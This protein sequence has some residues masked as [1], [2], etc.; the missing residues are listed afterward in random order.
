MTVH[1][2]KDSG[3]W[4]VCVN[5]KRFSSKKWTRA[6]ALA[7]EHKLESAHEHTLLDALG[8]WLDEYAPFLRAEANY[9][10]KA[11]ALRPLLEG[12]T[13][14]DIPSIAAEAR[15][16]WATLKPATINRRLAILRRLCH[17]AFKEWHWIDQP[18]GGKIRLLAER[19]ERHVYLLRSEVER[20]RASCTDPEAG[21]LIVFAAFTGLRWSEMFRVT[22]R[23]V[24]NDA[25]RLDAR[26]KSGRPRTIPLHPRALA[27][28]KRLPF[29]ITPAVLRKQWDRARERCALQH[30]HWHDLRHTFASWLVQA[31]VSLQEVKEL[32]GHASIKMTERYAHLAPDN[33]RSAVSKL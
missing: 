21:D 5:G 27:I 4:E 26:T 2:R 10:R 1:R 7:Y 16:R 14:D 19:N 17:L 24:I 8:K 25:L 23:D 20:L 13:F 33:L 30:V 15:R 31:G 12:K 22:A 18:L 32:L 28:A 6:D 11:E 9:R 29:A 3:S